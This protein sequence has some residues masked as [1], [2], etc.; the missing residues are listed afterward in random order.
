[1]SIEK[2]IN[3]LDEKGFVDIDYL[4]LVLREINNKVDQKRAAGKIKWNEKADV[5][6]VNKDGVNMKKIEVSEISRSGKLLI[7]NSE[8]KIII[9]KIY[10]V[11]EKNIYLNE[12]V[13]DTVLYIIY[14]Y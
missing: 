3:K 6:S 14:E 7:Y 8:G 11:E 5:I 10:S 13:Q 1:M 2:L 12:S 9:D 4:K